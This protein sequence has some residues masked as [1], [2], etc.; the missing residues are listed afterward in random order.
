MASL[1]SLTLLHHMATTK[2]STLETEL[3]ES[4]SIFDE[5]HLMCERRFGMSWCAS[6]GRQFWSGY[7]ELM[8]KEEGFE[9]RHNIY[10]LYHMCAHVVVFS[11]LKSLYDI[12]EMNAF[13]VVIVQLESLQYLWGRYIS[14]FRR[15]LYIMM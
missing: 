2:Q 15:K 13:F 9:D 10:T 8:P 6:L 12:A 1:H 11:V 5:L 3:W 7:R 14:L 4:C